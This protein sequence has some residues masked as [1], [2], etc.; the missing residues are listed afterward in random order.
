MAE[1]PITC[2]LE[3]INVKYATQEYHTEDTYHQLEVGDLTSKYII[4]DTDDNGEPLFKVKNLT[5]GEVSWKRFDEIE[6]EFKFCRL[7]DIE[8][9]FKYFLRH[10]INTIKA[11][12]VAKAIIA[13]KGVQRFIELYLENPLVKEL[14]STKQFYHG[15]KISVP[16]CLDLC[17]DVD[18]FHN[19][20]DIDLAGGGGE[21]S[22]NIRTNPAENRH[23][24]IFKPLKND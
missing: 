8:I 12:K 19:S 18:D 11:V 4:I 6:Y 16:G 5:T 10:P 22:F 2:T 17:G 23:P 24:L 20:I 21:M 7:S 13:R 3:V 14:I 1:I 15:S 9:P